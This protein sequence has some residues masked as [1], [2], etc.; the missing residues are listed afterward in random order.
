MQR[1]ARGGQALPDDHMT[2]Y[3]VCGEQRAVA[4]AAEAAVGGDAVAGDLEEVDYLT[5]AVDHAYAV[6]DGR[7][8]VVAALGVEAEAVAAAPPEA[9]D[10]PLA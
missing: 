3:G 5:V 7:A 1:Q 9:L 6:L 8:D 4:G 10:D 2:R